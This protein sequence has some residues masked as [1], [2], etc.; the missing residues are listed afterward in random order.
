MVVADSADWLLV[1]VGVPVVAVLALGVVVCVVVCRKRSVSDGKRGDS[2]P[3]QLQ[4]PDDRY[5]VI[6]LG[7][8]VAQSQYDVGNVLTPSAESDYASGRVVG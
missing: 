4:V 3:A 8:A 5:G 7:P 2:K 1:V 6:P